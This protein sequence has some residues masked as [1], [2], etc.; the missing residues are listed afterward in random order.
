MVLLLLV[1]LPKYI[2]FYQN[3]LW[4]TWRFV[5]WAPGARHTNGISIEFEIRPKYAVH[6]FEMQSTNHNEILHTSRQ[7][8]CRDVCKISLWSTSYILN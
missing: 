2:M 4:V 6:W 1:V 3:I 8:N 5:K 7:C